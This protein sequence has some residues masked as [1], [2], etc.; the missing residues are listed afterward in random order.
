MSL[1]LPAA[2]VAAD[3]VCEPTWRPAADS[4]SSTACSGRPGYP[5]N[6]QCLNSRW[7][8]RSQTVRLREMEDFFFMFGDVAEGHVPITFSQP[9]Q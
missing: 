6:F 5:Q 3:P 2:A 7:A 4:Q 9:L 8:D 1:L